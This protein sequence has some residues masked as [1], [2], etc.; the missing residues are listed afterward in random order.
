M[1]YIGETVETKIRGKLIVICFIAAEIGAILATVLGPISYKIVAL[2]GALI[3][4][5]FFIT[6]YFMPETP[7]YYLRKEKYISAEEVLVKLRGTA[8]V[9]EEL[10]EMSNAVK[11]SMQ[12]TGTIGDLIRI[13]KCRRAFLIVLGIFFIFS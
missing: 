4:L 1:M 10:T 6:F 11:Q 5:L 13:P 2:V 3:P 8:D 12:N 7:Y 9:K